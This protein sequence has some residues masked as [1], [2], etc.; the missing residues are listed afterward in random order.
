VKL[1][2]LNLQNNKMKIPEEILSKVLGRFSTP[3]L[4]GD[5]INSI[6]HQIISNNNEAEDYSSWPRKIRQRSSSEGVT[7]YSILLIV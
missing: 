5:C 7:A 4:V 1:Q 6:V 2:T 3:N